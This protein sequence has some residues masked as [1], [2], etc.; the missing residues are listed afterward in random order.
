[1]A[2][3]RSALGQQKRPP[4]PQV[5]SISTLTEELMVAPGAVS[6][7]L[8]SASCFVVKVDRQSRPSDRHMLQRVFRP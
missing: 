4:Y 5:I 1:V 8:Q 2:T 7:N 3:A 6:G